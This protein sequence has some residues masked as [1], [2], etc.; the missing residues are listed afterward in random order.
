[1][2]DSSINASL[3]RQPDAESQIQLK[4]QYARWAAKGQLPP[5]GEVGFKCYSQTDEDGILL[6]LFAALGAPHRTAVELCA[7]NGIECNSANLIINHGWT[8]LLLDGDQEMVEEGQRFYQSHPSTYVYPPKF[9]RSWITR[10]SVN[11]VI[12]GAGFE[13]EIDLLSLDMDGIDYWIWEALTV[14][15]PRVIVVEYQDIL[16]P[17]R[18]VTV[19]YADDFD[20]RRYP[21]S[22]TMPNF[23]G[24]S[25][26]AFTKLAARK[27]YRLV[28]CN[29][30]GYNAF[31]VRSDLRPDL[32]P[33]IPV[34]ACFDHPKVRAGM[35]ERY[36]LVADLPWVE[37]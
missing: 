19:P 28:G 10:D 17:D 4:L 34:E 20:A 30:Y 25:L 11:D 22:G 7:G 29:R 27:G 2:L 5:I 14:V 12:A 9:V 16:G 23:S 35:A 21:M 15:K 8:G 33:E 13:G 26:R 37:V 32:V 24:A 1:M 3:A 36:P 31:F 18:S 6:Y